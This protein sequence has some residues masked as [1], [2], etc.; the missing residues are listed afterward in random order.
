MH[1]RCIRDRSDRTGS[2]STGDQ[3]QG[4][5]YFDSDDRIITTP[6]TFTATGDSILRAGATPIFVDIRPDTFNLAPDGK[7]DAREDVVDRRA[8]D[9][10][11]H[12]RPHHGASR[13]RTAALP[14]MRGIITKPRGG[15]AN[16]PGPGH[17][18]GLAR[19]PSRPISR[20]RPIIRRTAGEGS[21]RSILPL[22]W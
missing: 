6:F 3:A 1:G 11:G 17:S 8:R 22:G 18:H 4:K 5:E 15:Q 16:R 7:V 19:T 13:S 20:C 2:Q 21:S 12:S 9:P 14:A 10:Q